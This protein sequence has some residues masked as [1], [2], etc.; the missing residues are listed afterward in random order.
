ML[1]STNTEGGRQ[2]FKGYF[3]RESKAPHEHQV[4]WFHKTL[5]NSQEQLYWFQLEVEAKTDFDWLIK[6]KYKVGKQELK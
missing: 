3:S 6:R 1:D 5:K 4:I 2:G